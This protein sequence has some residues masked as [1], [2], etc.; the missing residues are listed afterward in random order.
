MYYILLP[1]KKMKQRSTT[2]QIVLLVYTY[3]HKDKTYTSKQDLFK[4]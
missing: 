1:K 4:N 2:L 3:E